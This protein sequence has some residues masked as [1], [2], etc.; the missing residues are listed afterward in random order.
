MAH[1]VRREV[2]KRG[3]FG[4]LF[5]IIFLAFN[6]LM[7]AW[8]ISYWGTIGNHLQTGS[9]AEQAGTAIGA[10]LGTGMI[11][12]FWVLG[13]IVTGLLALLTRGGKTIV[14]EISRD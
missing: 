9:E 3:F 13:A 2:R 8:L 5:L 11:F 4:W 12:V 6:A 1:V 7:I 10:T 14:E